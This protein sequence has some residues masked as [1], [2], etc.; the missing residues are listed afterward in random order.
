MSRFQEQL[1]RQIGFLERSSASFDLG[2]TDEAVR[3]ATTIRILMHDTRSQVSLL[4]HLGA[5]GINLL[6]TCRQASPNAVLFSG[7]GIHEIGLEGGRL[8]PNLGDDE[9]WSIPAKD[10]WSQVIFVL[11]PGTRITREQ[12]VLT[13]ANKD[14]GAHVDRKLTPEYERLAQDGVLVGYGFERGG[15]KITEPA[16]EAH[17]VAIRT[18]AWELG[19]STELLDYEPAAEGNDS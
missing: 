18:M 6:S 19:H 10:W 7:M 16:R 17:F 12:L 4:T 15:E 13:A 3:M 1:R 14:G 9:T 8:R 2:Y 11:P 5:W